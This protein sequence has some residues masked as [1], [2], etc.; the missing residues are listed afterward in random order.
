MHHIREEM[1]HEQDV[2]NLDV[3][4]FKYQKLKEAE[5][6]WEAFWEIRLLSN[7]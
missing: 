2:A 5:R 4:I 7:T 1:K 6:L 3:L